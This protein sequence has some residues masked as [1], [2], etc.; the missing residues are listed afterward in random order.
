MVKWFFGAFL[1]CTAFTLSSDGVIQNLYPF[2]IGEYKLLKIVDGKKVQFPSELKKSYGV[3]I[4]K[5][6]KLHLFTNGKRTAKHTFVNTTM[7]FLQDQNHLVISVSNEFQP[8]FYRTDT[9]I[10][11]NFPEEFQDNYFVKIK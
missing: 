1:F 9:L 4:S 11:N 10:L 2:L 5:N 6:D 3:K 7:P 8:I